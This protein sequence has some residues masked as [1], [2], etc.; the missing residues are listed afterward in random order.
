VTVNGSHVGTLPV[1]DS[2]VL[3]AGNS[4]CRHAYD[5][6]PAAVRRQPNRTRLILDSEPYKVGSTTKTAPASPEVY[7]TG[8]IFRLRLEPAPSCTVLNSSSTI[9]NVATDAVPS[10][11]SSHVQ[12]SPSVGAKRATQW[13]PD[14]KLGPRAERLNGAPPLPS[15]PF[16]S[17]SPTLYPYLPF[18]SSPLPNPPIALLPNSPSLSLTPPFPLPSSPPCSLPLPL[19]LPFPF[20]FFCFFPGGPGGE[21]PGNF[22]HASDAPR[23]VLV[24][25]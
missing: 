17:I 7:E 21:A 24:H 1:G 9:G 11:I 6:R 5:L 13:R 19:P 4:K 16:P 18:S 25:C 22:F 10:D 20:P 2:D 15:S 3:I 8:R 14:N 12:S 23:R